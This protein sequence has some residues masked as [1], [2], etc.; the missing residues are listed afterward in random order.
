MMVNNK[1]LS[2]NKKNTNH[3]FIDNFLLIDQ[4]LDSIQN[5][6]NNN[7]K[8]NSNNYKNRIKCKNM[9]KLNYLIMMNLLLVKCKK[10][11]IIRF[12]NQNKKYSVKDKNQKVLK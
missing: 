7:M 4:P 2:T 11:Q 1:I 9:M 6:L 12:Y 8:R 10:K 5:R 3:K